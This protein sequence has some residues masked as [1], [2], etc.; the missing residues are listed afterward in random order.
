MDV[1]VT[2][3]GTL[4]VAPTVSPTVTVQVPLSSPGVTV[5]VTCAPLVAGV[6]VV[7]L[8]SATNRSATGDWFAGLGVQLIADVKLPA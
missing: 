5:K 6:A 3:T 7:G 8:I 2:L 4:T 1:L